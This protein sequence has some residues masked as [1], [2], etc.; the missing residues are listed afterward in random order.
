LWVKLKVRTLS[1]CP[2][3]LVVRE[4]L[5]EGKEGEEGHMLNGAVR[6]AFVTKQGK[7]WEALPRI[8]N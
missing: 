6:P 5:G 7:G 1:L 8:Q 2:Q 4:Y 3:D